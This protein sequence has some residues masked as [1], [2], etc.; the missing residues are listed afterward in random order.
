MPLSDDEQRVLDELEASLAQDDPAL[1]AALRHQPVHPHAHVLPR[2]LHGATRTLRVHDAL[3]GH[4]AVAPAAP[5]VDDAEPETTVT[6]DRAAAV[7]GL[8]VLLLGLALL[9][10][11]LSVHPSVSVL[12]FAVMLGGALRLLGAARPGPTS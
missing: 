5:A 1:V 8:L 12:G 6:L 3:A 10:A 9:V 11:G 2:T 7:T 4:R